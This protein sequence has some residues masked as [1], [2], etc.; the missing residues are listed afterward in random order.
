[1]AFGDLAAEIL[2]FGL[3]FLNLFDMRFIFSLI[4]LWALASGTQTIAQ[5]SFVVN[6]PDSSPLIRTYT[7]DDGLPQ[8]TPTALVQTRDGYIWIATFGGLARFD[9]LNFTVFTTSDVPQLTNNRLTA[10]A[11]DKNGVLWIGSEDGDLISYKDGKFTAV[12]VSTGALDDAVT[13]AIYVDEDN[14]LWIGN[15]SGLRIYDPQ[16]NTTKQFAKEDLSR[17]VPEPNLGIRC[18]ATDAAG[19]LWMATGRALVRYSNG[20]FTHFDNLG[21]GIDPD[22]WRLESNPYGPVYVFLKDALVTFDG[23]DL[24]PAKIARNGIFPARDRSPNDFVY[25]D[26]VYRPTSTGL[27]YYPVEVGVAGTDVRSTLL[28]REAN[29]WVGA[30]NNLKRFTKRMISTFSLMSNGV[31]IPTTCIVGTPDG[32]VYVCAKSKLVH[33]K[34]GVASVVFERTDDNLI[35]LAVD[36]LTGTIWIGTEAKIYKFLNG[37][38][39]EFESPGLEGSKS[40]R[41]FIDHAGTLWIG[42]TQLGVKQYKNGTLSTFS[43]DDGLPDNAITRIFEDSKGVIWIGTRRGMSRIENDVVIPTAEATEITG[44]YV[45]DFYEDPDG[46]MWIG[47]YGDGLVLFRNGVMSTINESS[48]LAENVVSRI[49][50][51]EDDNLWIL[52]N[53]GVYSVPRQALIEVVEGRTKRVYC[54]VYGKADGMNVTEGNAI[55]HPG[56]WK[57]QDGKMWFPMI[58]GGIVVDPSKKTNAA[59]VFIE[60][61]LFDGRRSVAGTEFRIADG[62]KNLEISYTG[63]TFVRPEHVQFRYMLEGFDTA[64]QEA[65]TRRTAYY[66]NLPPGNYSFKVAAMNEAGEFGETAA[67]MRVV[68]EGPFRRTNAFYLM[69][70]VLALGL[71]FLAYQFRMRKVTRDQELEQEF[72]RQLI[73]AHESERKRVAGEIHDGIGHWLLTIKNGLML[74]INKFDR[75]TVNRNDL[76]NIVTMTT[77]ALEETRTISSNLRPVHLRR[78]GLT[79]SL[80]NVVQTIQQSSLTKIVANIDNVDDLFSPEDELSIYRIVQESLNNIIKHSYAKSAVINIASN[81][82]GIEI[83]IED[84]GV[85]FDTRLH[86]SM[87]GGGSTNLGLNN[88]RQRARLMGGKYTLKSLVSSGTLV[89]VTIPSRKVNS[90]D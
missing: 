69:L 44:D 18:F 31:P 67:T 20:T 16:L 66:P 90:N 12:K 78:F 52:G 14:L 73:D 30:Q 19:N 54:S 89:T 58:Q 38:V 83:S 32:S 81:D 55:N 43:K 5:T 1:M 39:V 4:L 22:I 11:E 84:D 34:D 68:V 71:I 33:F 57:T 23:I 72:A 51:D 76:A 63:V 8:N 40:F 45:R 24:L 87:A 6:P 53:R 62:E 28:D 56:G 13:R 59:P 74:A 50:S 48:G 77:S 21:E 82:R 17:K 7:T 65:G 75:Q 35:S 10:L 25:W 61:V 47:T 88:I 46:N 80:R 41:V 86:D 70:I 29:L 26:G 15:D 42:T 2:L 37:Q 85:G 36:S 27:E 9:G 60:S 49:F 3:H 79:G 64:W